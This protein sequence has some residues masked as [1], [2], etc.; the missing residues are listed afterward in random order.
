MADYLIPED[1]PLNLR[2]V[3]EDIVQKAE[4]LLGKRD[5]NY[6]LGTP[7]FDT[8]GPFVRVIP[9]QWAAAILSRNAAGYWPSA[10]WE[11]AY[12]CIHLLD[13][14][15]EKSNYLEEGIAA[16]FQEQAA[17]TLTQSQQQAPDKLTH[18]LHA[19]NLVGRLPVG[20]FEAAKKLRR[21]R[22]ALSSITV[23]DLQT[24]FPNVADADAQALATR[25]G[26]LDLEALEPLR[27]KSG[28]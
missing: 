14:T 16:L 11:L 2:Q 12:Q 28:C 13:P 7:E 20:P 18:Y 5:S 19:K 25:F 8:T 3:Q 4:R 26:D 15:I 17:P 22:G 10:I 21:H 23:S 1:E 9:K 6:H 27:T 24:L